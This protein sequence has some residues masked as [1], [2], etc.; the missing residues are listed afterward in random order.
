VRK[1]AAKARRDRRIPRWTA[2]RVGV[3]LSRK[4]QP[5]HPPGGAAIPS[6]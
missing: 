1:D 6:T 2:H 3:A 5:T 4:S